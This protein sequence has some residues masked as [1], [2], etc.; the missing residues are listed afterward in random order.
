MKP[1]I[2]F[3]PLDC[4]GCGDYLECDASPG[5]IVELFCMACDLVAMYQVLATGRVQ[6]LKVLGDDFEKWHARRAAEP[7]A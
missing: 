3:V 1:K 2:D 6:S 7:T 4:V 5:S